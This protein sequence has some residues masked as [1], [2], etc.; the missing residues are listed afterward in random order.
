[1]G[2]VRSETDKTLTEAGQGKAERMALG[3]GYGAVMRIIAFVL[4]FIALGGL[5]TYFLG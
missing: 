2:N 4:G 3:R 5:V 1:M